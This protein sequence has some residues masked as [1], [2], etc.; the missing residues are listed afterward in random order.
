M[1][2]SGC[3]QS[4]PGVTGSISVHLPPA[5]GD[6]QACFS[7]LV[8]VPTGDTMSRQQVVK[9]VADLKQSELAKSLCGRRLLAWYA[10]AGSI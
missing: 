10:K 2:L 3:G 1:M 8:K 7:R 6:V 4:G 9:L 5:P